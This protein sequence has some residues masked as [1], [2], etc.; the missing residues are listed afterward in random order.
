MAA[1]RT[2]NVQPWRV[3]MISF[4]TQISVVMACYNAAAYLQESIDSVLN[5]TFPDFELIVVDD[6][7]TDNTAEM[8]QAFARRD[9]R[10][11][12]YRQDE[13]R[14]PAVARN[15]ALE[16]A[17]GKW[18]AIL[19]A[20]DVAMATRLERQ[21]AYLETNPETVLLGSGCIEVDATGRPLRTHRYPTG[22]R[23]LIRRLE[24]GR[25]FPPHSSCIYHAETVR[26]LGGFNLRFTPS[27]DRDL[28]QRLGEIGM[29]GCHR[30]RLVKL[31]RYSGSLSYQD[32]GKTQ[33]MHGLAATV[34]HFLRTNHD[35]DPSLEDEDTWRQFTSW[36][37][38]RLEQKGIFTA[39]QRWTQLREDF[40]CSESNRIRRFG[41]LA[42][43]IFPASGESYRMVRYRFF[44]SGLARQLA[45]EWYR[46]ELHIA[47]RVTM[48]S[49]NVPPDDTL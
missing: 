12:Y 21:L 22:H 27:E 46:Q 39:R 49:T 36:M 35:V 47:H 3:G 41:R 17:T 13:N 4:T 43:R 9:H 45:E 11:R 20:D 29:L 40:L 5:Q 23:E 38:L 42:I 10:I 32:S 34:C 31:R 24:Q 37:K 48:E 19:D 14:G 8:M 6:A 44:G 25:A 2:D 7:S 26:S 33:I 1:T 28:W 30:E 15:T 18:I 16:L